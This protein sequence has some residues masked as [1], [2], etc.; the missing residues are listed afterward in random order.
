MS[1]ARREGSDGESIGL[2]FSWQISRIMVEVKSGGAGCS[3][4]GRGSHARF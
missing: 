3:D 2:I 4:G 1:A